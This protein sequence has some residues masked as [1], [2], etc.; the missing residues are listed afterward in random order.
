M[1]T[2]TE[3]EQ[4]ILSL[5][6]KGDKKRDASDKIRGYIFQNYITIMCLLEENVECVCL[7]YLEDV[8][9][10]FEDGTFM[11]IQVKYYPNTGL[12]MKEIST[13]LYYQY[14]R[15]KM[16]HSNLKAVPSLYIHRNSKVKKPTLEK[17]KKYLGLE[18]KL[19]K[20]INYTEISD[21]EGW[22]ENN[23][24]E[25]DKK[26]DQ[27]KKLFKTMASE[28]SLNEFIAEYNICNKSNI[29]QYK[30]EL[31]EALAK[32]Y[33]N[34]DND[35]ELERWKSIL[36]GLAISYIQR[37]YTLNNTTCFNQLKMSKKDYN[38]YM[39]GVVGT[40]TN[41]IIVSYLVDIVFE[42]YEDI[43]YYNNLSDLQIYMLNLIY[44]NTVKWV[45][46]ISKDAN[47]QNQLLNTLSVSQ[48]CELADYRK[49]SINL[50]LCHLAECKRDFS[51]FLRY[52]WKIILDICQDKVD[53]LTEISGHLELLDPHHYIDSSVKEYV[54]LNFPED[55]YVN[56]TVILPS[57]E[58]DFKGVKRKIVGRMIKM[59]QKPEKWFFANSKFMQ[60][61]NYY[62]YSTAD[63][64]ENPT[65][66][67]LGEDSFYIE[68]MD[69]I[70]IEEGKW[71]LKEKCDDCIFS[72]ECI[73]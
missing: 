37:R 47:G 13:D 65:I 7:E 46:D 21:I 70:K 29:S 26:D 4:K 20:S 3:N 63:I 71:N 43:R 25:N 48:G 34:S 31:K 8:D 15:L 40:R 42:T 72:L 22:L 14:L 66:V 67:D 2:L 30:E 36:F 64:N 44:Q 45:S 23:I 60:G 69:C 58:G 38:Q 28:E 12:N 55:R 27:K 61:K 16:L 5:M 24:Y 52:F 17:M 19:K 68:C 50:R 35:M 49:I 41:Q 62:L 59:H 73:K 51:N 6:Y 32:T 18:N 10:F 53:D 54:C 11:F 57:A 33:P 1:S 56:R 9:V 39:I